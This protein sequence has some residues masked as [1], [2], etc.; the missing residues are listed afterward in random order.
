[1]ALLNR[2]AT[3]CRLEEGSLYGNGVCS[4][5]QTAQS[6]NRGKTLFVSVLLSGRTHKCSKPFEVR[7]QPPHPS[8][9]PHMR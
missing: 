1:M 8:R 9:I 2:K 7:Q 6:V 3:K 4:A 5:S